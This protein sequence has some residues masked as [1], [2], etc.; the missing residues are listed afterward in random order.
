MSEDVPGIVVTGASS[1]F[2]LAT[3]RLLAAAGHL[4][5]AVARRADRLEALAAEQHP[6]RIVP[7]AIDVRDRRAVMAVLPGLAEQGPEVAALVN[8]AGLSRGYGP[9]ADGD[10]DDWQQMID[11]NVSGMLH[12]TRALL[13]GMIA[14]GAGHVVNV[15]SIAASYPYLGGNVYA[16][17]KAFVQQLSLNL[18]SELNGTGVR[19]SC[20][21]PGMARTGFALVRFDGDQQRADDFYRGTH[22]LDAADIARTVVWCLDQPPH[23]NVNL[24]EIMPTDQPF[25]LGLA[26]R[27]A[28][29][30]ADT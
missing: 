14:R 13:P 8:S 20:I 6:G 16:A 22:P 3:A 9:L 11:T 21:S 5:Y 26:A 7:L 10:P 15:G 25:A 28:P 2:G 30:L 29:D 18:R 12:C 19:V 4:V 23:V 17:T 27:P 1:G 24:I